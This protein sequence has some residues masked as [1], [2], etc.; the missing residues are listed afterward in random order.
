M[1]KFETWL[2][3]VQGIAIDTL[4]PDDLLFWRRAFDE[5]MVRGSEWQAKR[6]PSRSARKND[7]RYAIAIEDGNELG[8]TFWIK[9]SVNG[10]IFLFYPRNS[11]MDPHASYHLDGTYHQK[12]YGQK[13]ISQKRQPLT[14]KFAGAEHLGMFAG[15]GAGPR[16]HNLDDFDD[17][18]IAPPGVL[19][20]KSGVVVVDLVEPGGAPATHH[21]QTLQIAAERT[22]QDASPWIVVAIA[23]TKR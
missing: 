20:G 4:G 16:I 18:F 8:L 6:A 17:V 9:R 2:K 23:E 3:D 10:E 22:Y 7:R 21:R 5:A 19:T 13:G 11:E 1:D 12:T 14:C 15:H